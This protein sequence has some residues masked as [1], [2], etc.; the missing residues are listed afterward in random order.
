VTPFIAIFRHLKAQGRVGDN[1]LIF[2]NKTKKDIILE[3]EF[4]EMLGNNFI[5]IL[6]EETVEG[7]GMDT[8]LRTS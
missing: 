2:A 4:K 3:K 1:K 6:S 7:M 5:S 8:S